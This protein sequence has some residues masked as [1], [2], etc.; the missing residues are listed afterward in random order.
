M[1]VELE[2]GGSPPHKQTTIASWMGEW[3]SI[4]ALM[5]SI[6]DFPSPSPPPPPLPSDVPADVGHGGEWRPVS[7]RLARGPPAGFWP[8]PQHSAVEVISR[9]SEGEV[10][11]A[12]GG[13]RMAQPN[14]VLPT[15]TEGAD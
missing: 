12:G 5:N 15:H 9:R 7:G 6:T 10:G 2:V 11:V 14:N 3:L 4:S 8:D 1:G 13:S